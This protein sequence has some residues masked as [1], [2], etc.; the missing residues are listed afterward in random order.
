VRR[1]LSR[2]RGA[3]FGAAFGAAPGHVQRWPKFAKNPSSELRAR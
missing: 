2:I 1:G 3:A